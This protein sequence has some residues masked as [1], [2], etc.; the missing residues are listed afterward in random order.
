MLRPA[1]SARQSLGRVHTPNYEQSTIET[2][3]NHSLTTQT[4]FNHEKRKLSLD[5][6]FPGN[7]DASRP[8]L[9]YPNHLFILF[10]P[11]PVFLRA[12]DSFRFQDNYKLER[13]F[14]KEKKRK[15]SAAEQSCT[16]VYNTCHMRN[17]ICKTSGFS[18]VTVSTSVD[19]MNE[20]NLLSCK[21]VNTYDK[22]HTITLS[23]YTT[24]RHKKKA[25]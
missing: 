17:S 12:C 9:P 16:A 4:I 22:I 19:A 2:P 21:R 5:I 24:K 23:I 14:S 25:T 10:P 18:S 3:N 7:R 11:T 1:S 8:L 20:H 13:Y 15:T 6:E